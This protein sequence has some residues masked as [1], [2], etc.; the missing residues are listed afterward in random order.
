MKNTGG[1]SLPQLT[2]KIVRNARKTRLDAFAVALEGW[3]RGLKLKCPLHQRGVHTVVSGCEPSE[4]M[5]WRTV[6]PADTR[7]PP[8]ATHRRPIRSSAQAETIGPSGALHHDPS[9]IRSIAAPP[10]AVLCCRRGGVGLPSASCQGQVH[11]LWCSQDP[12]WSP[13]V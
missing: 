5:T 12:P 4:T 13:S 2:N 10:A 1:V 9:S 6:R 8:L 11:H 3:R 7:T